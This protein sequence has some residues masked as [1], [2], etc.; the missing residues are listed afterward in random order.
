MQD[1]FVARYTVDPAVD[2]MPH[3]EGQFLACSFWLA[4]NYVLQG[5]LKEAEH[6]LNGC[7]TFA[8]TS[9]CSPKNTIRLQNASWATSRRHFPT[10][11][12]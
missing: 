3:G 9:D 4:D 5:R 12:W 1:G 11:V 6:Y 7:S 10:S 2:G 8:T